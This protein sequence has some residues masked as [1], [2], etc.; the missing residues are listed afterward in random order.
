[1]R[2]SPA[3]HSFQIIMNVILNMKMILIRMIFMKEIKEMIIRRA[4]KQKTNSIKI[5]GVRYK[6]LKILN[7]YHKRI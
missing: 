7:N 4:K 6:I 1:M 3:I 2:R 5:R